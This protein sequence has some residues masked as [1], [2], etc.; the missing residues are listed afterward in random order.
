[1]VVT[2]SARGVAWMVMDDRGMKPGNVMLDIDAR[3][4][5]ILSKTKQQN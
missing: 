5:A 3:T 1:M 2:N 4:A